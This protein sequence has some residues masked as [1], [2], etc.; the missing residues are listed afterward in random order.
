MIF[1]IS[2]VLSVAVLSVAMCGA[3][4]SVLAGE[5]F[6][7]PPSPDCIFSNHCQ[8]QE[9][10]CTVT[11]ECCT[12]TCEPT[13]HA[14][15]RTPVQQAPAVQH[16]PQMVQRTVMTPQTYLVPQMVMVP[17]TRM[18]ANTIWERH[19]SVAVHQT[20]AVQNTVSQADVLQALRTIVLEKGCDIQ[21][22]P[23]ASPADTDELEDK[24]KRLEDRISKIET[25][26]KRLC[27]E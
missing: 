27:E 2:Y 26:L 10:C 8:K 23:A 3:E 16:Q 24:L 17:Q 25:R 12:S 4:H 19:D 21:K 15:A 9:E 11:E 1:R 5:F 14:P 6:K 13:Y 22:A 18:V 7:V 20:A